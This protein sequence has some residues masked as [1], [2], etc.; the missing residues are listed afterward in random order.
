MTELAVPLPVWADIGAGDLEWARLMLASGRAGRMV[1]VEKAPR[2]FARAERRARGDGR[3]RVLLGDGLGALPAELGAIEGAGIGG[4]GGR[5]IAAILTDAARLD[6]LPRYLV[7]APT[8]GLR[9]VCE[10]LEGLGYR[11]LRERWVPEGSH[12]RWVALWAHASAGGECTRPFWPGPPV[13]GGRDGREEAL[14]IR[15]VC[16][17]LRAV[18]RSRAGAPADLP[19]REED[20]RL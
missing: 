16:E 11:R 4:L 15:A 10:H 9:I 12:V 6:R 13:A 1:C 3:I 14:C 20:A 2:P 19:C 5:T 18:H 17:K 8:H 7:V